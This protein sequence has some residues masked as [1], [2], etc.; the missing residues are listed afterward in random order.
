LISEKQLG[1][2]VKSAIEDVINH[3]IEGTRIKSLGI[4]EA[5]IESVKTD[6]SIKT[7]TLSG[8][9][10]SSELMTIVGF[11]TGGLIYF[12]IIFYGTQVMRGVI[13]EKT[14]RIIEVL[15][16]SVKPFELMMGK[17]LGIALVGLTAICLMGNSDDFNNHCSFE[18]ILRLEV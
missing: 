15:I 3:E 2:E 18:G 4:T 12:F 13:E 10:N 7:Q 6:I 16:S 17:I 14:N 5:Q 1:I 11:F 9:D 8:K